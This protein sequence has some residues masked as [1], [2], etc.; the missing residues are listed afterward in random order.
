MSRFHILKIAFLTVGL[1]LLT[2]GCKTT[3]VP[4]P[5]AHGSTPHS[6]RTPASVYAC[7]M[8][9]EVTGKAGDECPKCGMDLVP[10]GAPPA[11]MPGQIEMRFTAEP[12][13][14]KPGEDVSLVL[15]PFSK[16]QPQAKID[17][18]V[19]HTKKVHLIMVSDDLSWFEHVHPTELNDGTYRVLQK[20]PSPGAY[21]LFADYKPA[22]GEPAV[23]RLSLEIKG[24]APP[25]KDYQA[26]RLTSDAGEGFSAVLIPEGGQL[27][28]GQASHIE[29]K[30][31]KNGK[32]IDVN[33]LDDYLGEKAH[34]VII[35]LA[36]KEYLHVHPG[37]EGSAFD[38]HTTF[39]KPGIY[40]GWLQ[41]QS[42]N[43]VYTSDFVLQVRQGEASATPATTQSPGGHDGHDH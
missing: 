1:S 6:G 9:P 30:V 40:R 39:E 23:E 38:L 24:D 29:G 22:G 4:T 31:L 34:M 16:A 11:T 26:E 2:F 8:H 19:A 18:E 3:A 10:Q 33:T 43:K 27:L 13:R 7:P 28:T 41:F 17:L 32:E 12:E 20:F 14:P 37:V 36:D 25:A 35:G 5:A 21:T 42:A 15:T